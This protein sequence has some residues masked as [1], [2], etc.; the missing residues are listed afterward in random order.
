MYLPIPKS[1]YHIM[2]RIRKSSLEVL[3]IT[4]LSY[5]LYNLHLSRV[6]FITFV[7][8]DYCVYWTSE[9]YSRYRYV[10]ASS[11]YCCLLC[12][13]TTCMIWVIDLVWCILDVEIYLLHQKCK[14]PIYRFKYSN[15][16]PFHSSCIYEFKP[17]IP[18]ISSLIFYFFIIHWLISVSRFDR[19]FT[20]STEKSDILCNLFFKRRKAFNIVHWS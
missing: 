18:Y 6:N 15:R 19:I 1:I 2:I 3:N 4:L 13:W 8:L 7:S 20:E 16:I 12:R 14:Y 5:S 9:R 11:P 17:S 10:N